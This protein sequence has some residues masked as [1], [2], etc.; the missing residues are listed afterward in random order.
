M[1]APAE[2]EI[3]SR[4]D[5]S[6]WRDAYIESFV[7]TGSEHYQRRIAVK[8]AFSDGV[9]HAGYLWEC[10]KSSLRI[11][12][13]RF[14]HELAKHT[15]VL[16]MADDLSR[17]QVPGAPLWPYAAMSVA[18]FEPQ[19]L[20]R[21]LSILPEDLYAFDESLSWSLILTHEHDHKRRICLGIGIGP[22]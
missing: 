4:E 15:D 22:G 20:L 12:F 6:L 14:R 16:V 2:L 13:E 1:Q 7:E 10:L 8:R 9:H 5:S 17:D 21:A 3:L 11:T 18:R 19:R